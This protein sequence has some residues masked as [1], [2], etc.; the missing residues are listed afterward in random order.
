MVKMVNLCYVY[1]PHS[2]KCDYRLSQVDTEVMVR[3]S[4]HVKYYGTWY[5]KKL[6]NKQNGSH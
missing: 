1:L 6:K 4:G 3:N 2:A 5:S